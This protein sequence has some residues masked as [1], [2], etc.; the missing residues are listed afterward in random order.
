MANHVPCSRLHG[1]VVLEAFERHHPT[2]LGSQ[3]C[4]ISRDFFGDALELIEIR[5]E[6]RGEGSWSRLGSGLER[7]ALSSSVSCALIR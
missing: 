3:Y 2:E 7:S 5:D 4:F 1:E 6:V